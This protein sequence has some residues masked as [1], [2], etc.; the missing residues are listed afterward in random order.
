[1]TMVL[2]RSSQDRYIDKWMF[3][4]HYFSQACVQEKTKD[5]KDPGK[6]K[7]QKRSYR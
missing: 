1:M 5:K 2:D 3:Q 4:S 6:D 7:R